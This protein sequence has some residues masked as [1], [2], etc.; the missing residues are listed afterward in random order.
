M[1]STT[2]T[3]IVWLVILAAVGLLCMLNEERRNAVEMKAAARDHEH[4]DGHLAGLE[5]HSKSRNYT[6]Y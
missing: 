1:D 3:A 5:K 4:R 2:V 6:V